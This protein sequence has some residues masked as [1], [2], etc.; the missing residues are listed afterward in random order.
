MPLTDEVG[1]GPEATGGDTGGHI[2]SGLKNLNVEAI[3]PL[4]PGSSKRDDWGCSSRYGGSLHGREKRAYQS[5]PLKVGGNARHEATSV[6]ERCIPSLDVL[7]PW[8][9]NNVGPIEPLRMGHRMRQMICAVLVMGASDCVA[10]GSI[11]DGNIANMNR[12]LLSK[13]FQISAE[14]IW[15]AGKK[16]RLVFYED[17]QEI[18]NLIKLIESRDKQVWTNPKEKQDRSSSGVR[19][20]IQI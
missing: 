9:N 4:N 14:D 13:G 18:I 11:E 5:C 2:T 1:F 7:A 16:L 19:N 12:V 20:Q 17:E 8:C 6:S 15:C 3:H 10:G